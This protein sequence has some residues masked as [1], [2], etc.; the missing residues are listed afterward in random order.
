[1][2]LKRSGFV[3]IN[4]AKKQKTPQGGVPNQTISATLSPPLPLYRSALVLKPV[5]TSGLL[6]GLIHP[7][8][9]YA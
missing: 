6:P 4:Y 9:F 8:V 2:A 3:Q 5:T 7:T 1:M